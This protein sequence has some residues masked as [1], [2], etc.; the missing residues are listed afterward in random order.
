MGPAMEFCHG[1]LPWSPAMESCHGVPSLVLSCSSKSIAVPIA[2]WVPRAF[3][4]GVAFM[5]IGNPI[6]PRDS[7]WPGGDKSSND[8]QPL[9]LG[10]QS[11]IQVRSEPTPAG[12]SL[13]RLALPKNSRLLVE[14]AESGAYT[15][16]ERPIEMPIR[17]LSWYRCSN[18]R[19]ARRS[20]VPQPGMRRRMLF[21]RLK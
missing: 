21:P 15:P 17:G 12:R 7:R 10:N 1:V 13:Q 5:F 6:W 3:H 9:G 14:L 20:Q 8:I 19:E 2:E 18:R 11:W 16:L 4:R